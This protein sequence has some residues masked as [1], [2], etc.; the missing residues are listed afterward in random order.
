MGKSEAI[1][2]VDRTATPTSLQTSE[3]SFEEKAEAA[4]KKS[5]LEDGI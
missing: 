2:I 3:W 1:E 5:Y 4:E